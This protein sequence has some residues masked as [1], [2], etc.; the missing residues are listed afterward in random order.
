MESA[1]SAPVVP[2]SWPSTK[3]PVPSLR[4]RTPLHTAR[5]RPPASLVARASC[6]ALWV[7]APPRFPALWSPAAATTL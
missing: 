4:L 5:R 6:A 7:C 1:T 3:R 2:V